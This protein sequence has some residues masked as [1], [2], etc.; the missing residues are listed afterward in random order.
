MEMEESGGLGKSAAISSCSC[1]SYHE[2][3]GQGDLRLELE[4]GHKMY[5][6]II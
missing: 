5:S 3:H 1:S 4:I 6:G 2:G